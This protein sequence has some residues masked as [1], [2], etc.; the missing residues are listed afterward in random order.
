[1]TRVFLILGDAKLCERLRG[2]FQLEGDFAV[3]GGVRSGVEVVEK[4]AESIPDLI[5]METEVPPFAAF[6]L[7]DQIKRTMPMVPIFIIAERQTW[8]VEKEARL[9]GINA[10]FDKEDDFSSLLMNARVECGVGAFK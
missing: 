6:E 3:S 7:A 1:M 10:V 2:V 4:A 9:H 5:L 8:Q